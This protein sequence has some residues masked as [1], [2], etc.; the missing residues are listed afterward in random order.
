MIDYEKPS[1]SDSEL[2]ARAKG[3]QVEA[4]GQLYER[5]LDPIYRFIRMRV[6][7]ERDAE[8]L[9][10]TVFLRTYEALDRYEDRGHPFSAYLYQVAKNLLADHY[11]QRSRAEQVGEV[12]SEESESSGDRDH[13]EELLAIAQALG[14]LSEDYREVIRLRVVLELPTETVA[15]WM[16]RTPGA[17]RVL[18]HRA[19]KEL[20]RNLDKDG[21]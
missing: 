15:S 10:E 8:D 4:F 9:C 7:G 14:H 17:V 3:G 5:Y 16:G 20:N 13:Q 1:P 11:R 2:V 19:L 18:L 21:A 6:D 12:E